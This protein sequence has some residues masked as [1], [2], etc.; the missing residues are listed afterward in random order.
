MYHAQ[1]LS[2]ARALSLSYPAHTHMHT[3]TNAHAH[4]HA[5][6]H[7]RYLPAAYGEIATH[8][9]AANAAYT[10]E[11]TTKLCFFWEINKNEIKSN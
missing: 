11:I 6:T 3:H 10:V 7:T 1:L 2:R 5:R 4:T 9:H 8:N